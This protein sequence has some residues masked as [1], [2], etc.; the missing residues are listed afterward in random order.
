[1][2]PAELLRAAC[3]AGWTAEPCRSG[4]WRLRHP[5]AKEA[6]VMP[7]TPSDHRWLANARSDMK[8][9]LGKP[10]MQ[11]T[12]KAPKPKAKASPSR[13]DKPRLPAL[14]TQEGDR[15]VT[16]ISGRVL[17]WCR[18]DRPGEPTRW[19]LA[20]PGTGRQP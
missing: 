1:M 14:L 4:H 13:T 2:S 9:A 6:V 12:V 11:P 8:R 5:E 7:A 10:E 19:R 17:T 18:E 20:P 3:K 15:L 16:I